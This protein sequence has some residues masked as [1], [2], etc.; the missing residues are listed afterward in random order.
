MQA[1]MFGDTFSMLKWIDRRFS[2]NGL[3]GIPVKALKWIYWNL[4][5][6]HLFLH[7]FRTLRDFQSSGLRGVWLGF[8]RRRL[9]PLRNRLLCNRP[10]NVEIGDLSFLMAPIGAQATD[11]WS[12]SRCEHLE[13]S[14]IMEILQPGMVFLDIGANAGV[15]TLAAAKK[16][17]DV[18]SYAFEP[19]K[20]TFQL[21]ENNIR[22]NSLKNVQAYR[23][24]LGDYCG[25][26]TMQL[27]DQ[28]LD[29]LN[30]IGQP[31]HPECRVVALEEVM[32][33]T[34]SEFLG[35]HG[36]SRVDAIKADV[37]GA[38]LLVFEG[39]KDLLK[40]EDAPIILYESYAMCT[41]GFK[42]HPV[43]IMWYLR[44][45]GYSFFLFDGKKGRI[46]L[47]ERDHGYDAMFI[48]AKPKKFP[49]LRRF[50]NE[51]CLN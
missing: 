11:V 24:A 19:C 34:L 15:F 10:V 41:K 39:A 7:R 3:R 20:W 40:R 25:V 49:V 51:S 12:R 48:A 36:I 31:S 23:V 6:H 17:P 14:F 27:N 43:E 45:C 16:R 46:I 13:I 38:E 22:L 8:R 26:A 32:I 42:Y 5:F 35:L 28:G 37:E 50:M 18:I 30:T 44:D 2:E 33:M 4:G 9:F 29:G 47:R 1:K 21:L